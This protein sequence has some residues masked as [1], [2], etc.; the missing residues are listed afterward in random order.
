[1]DK[2][3]GVAVNTG[4][5][6]WE[7]PW[8][9]KTAVIPTPIVKGNEIYI[10]SGYGIGCMKVRIESDNTVTEVYKNKNM[11]NHHGGVILL[12]DHLYS[13]AGGKRGALVCQNFETGELVWENM[14][15]VKKGAVY[16]ADGK[17]YIVEE[18]SG[19]VILGEASSKGWKE[20]SRF[21]LPPQPDRRNP[22]GKIWVHPVI[23][24]GKLYLRDQEIVYC[25]DVAG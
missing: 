23:S 20:I 5:L 15:A 10:T 14:K 6:I 7:T 18:S 2:L 21:T 22:K 9:G 16:Y 19:T 13:L 11:Q 25:F 24:D 8:N 4:K 1:M 3:V 12:G 17:L